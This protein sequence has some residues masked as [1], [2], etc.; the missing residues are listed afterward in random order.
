MWGMAVKYRRLTELALER[1]MDMRM[2]QLQEEGVEAT[3]LLRR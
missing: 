2:L 1:F 3:F